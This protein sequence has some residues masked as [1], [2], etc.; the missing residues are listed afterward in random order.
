MVHDHH[1]KY[2]QYMKKVMTKQIPNTSTAYLSS[3][4]LLH[5]DFAKQYTIMT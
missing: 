2:F 1:F 5:F 3:K 4:Q